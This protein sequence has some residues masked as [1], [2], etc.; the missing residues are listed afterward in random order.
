MEMQMEQLVALAAAALFM[1]FQ[2]LGSV[3]LMDLEP[4]VARVVR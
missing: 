2:G 4:A 1:M 3:Q